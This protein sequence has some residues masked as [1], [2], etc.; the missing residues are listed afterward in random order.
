M[1]FTQDAKNG[2]NTLGAVITPSV[3]C[4]I[5]MTP[6]VIAMLASKTCPVVAVSDGGVVAT[7]M[8]ASSQYQYE[9][10]RVAVLG[11]LNETVEPADPAEPGDPDAPDEPADPAPPTP[12]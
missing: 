2:R 8:S 3:C 9:V 1:F 12:P 5:F 7:M 11:R 4:A 10:E 6:S